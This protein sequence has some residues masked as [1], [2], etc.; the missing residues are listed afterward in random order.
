M[1]RLGMDVAVTTQQQPPPRRRRKKQ[2]LKN[3]YIVTKTDIGGGGKSATSSHASGTTTSNEVELV[4]TVNQALDLLI[5]AMERYLIDPTEESGTTLTNEEQQQTTPPLTEEQQL[6]L[7]AQ[8]ALLAS[9][10]IDRSLARQVDA[11]IEAALRAQRLYVTV[12]AFTLIDGR[13]R[14]YTLTETYDQVVNESA[15]AEAL[16]HD[17]LFADMARYD[18]QYRDVMQICKYL[19]A[20]SPPLHY[21]LY[22]RR[23]TLL[24]RDGHQQEALGDKT[25]FWS[26]HFL[27]S[28]TGYYYAIIVNFALTTQQELL[29]G[30]K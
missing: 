5:D 3:L 11:C 23:I 22:R 15:V 2:S 30:E 25:G 19:R 7:H 14:A 29:H 13:Y 26:R 24:G 16:S 4:A 17:A 10:N 21:T 27:P 6:L 8:G 12:K 9:L 1:H 18:W 28:A 20:R